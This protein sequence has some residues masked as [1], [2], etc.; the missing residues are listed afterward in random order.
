MD[1]N[2]IYSYQNYLAQWWD[3][4]KT[5]FDNI[6]LQNIKFEEE[7]KSFTTK[8]NR[9]K[10]E[11]SKYQQNNQESQQQRWDLKEKLQDFLTKNYQRKIKKFIP[12]EIIIKA[13]LHKSRSYWTWLFAT[14]STIQRAKSYLCT[15]F[16]LNDLGLLRDYLGVEFS[17]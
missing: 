12:Q 7:N 5:K 9:L 3:K 17:D 10:N 13:Y 1:L 14:V 6:S 2:I 16:D 11:R 8:I 4:T 15:T